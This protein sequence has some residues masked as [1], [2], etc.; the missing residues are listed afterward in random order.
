MT[1]KQTALLILVL[2]AILRFASQTIHAAQPVLPNAILF[3]TQP[4]IPNEVND[5][6][7]L[8]VF[9]SV[10]SPLGNHLADTA[11]AGRGGDLWIRYPNG[12]LKNLTR[13]A[14]FGVDGPQHGAG[15]GVRDPH[16]HWSG[17]KA[18]FSMVVGAP[19]VAGDPAQ[20]FWQLYEITNLSA[21]VA[22]SNTVPAIVKVLNQ[23]AGYNNVMPCYGTDERVIFAC[24]R[25]RNG[26]PH[27]YPQL[28]EY[29]D[30]PTNTGLWS[31]DPSTGDLFQLEHSPSGSFNPFIDS[32]GRLLFTRWDHLVQDR[33]ATDDRMGRATNGTFNYYDEAGTAYS[34]T[35]RPIELFPEPRTYDSNLLAVLKVQGNAFNQFFPWMANEDGTA[36]EIL[37]HIGRHELLSTFRGSSFTNDPNLVQQFNLTSGLRYNTNSLNNFMEVREDPLNAG[38]YFGIDSPD[39]G[40]HGAGQI[41]TLYGPPGT[42]ADRMFLTYITPK[43]TD[44]P[45]S[46]G[47]YRNPLPLSNGGLVAAY[48]ATPGSALD[49]NVGSPAF[50]APRYNFRLMTLQ[51]SGA[52]WTTNQFLTSGLTNIATYWNGSTLITQTNG[53]WEL[54]PVEV[55]ARP[56]PARLHAAVAAVEAQVFAEEGVDIAAMQAWLAANGLALLVSRNVTTRD[57][58]DREQPFNLRVPGT[59]TQTLGTNTGTVYGVRYIQFFQADQLRGL[60]FGTTNLAPGRRVLATP[61]HEPAALAFNVPAT[62]GPPGSTRLGDD[63]SQA[64][65]LPARR[66]M[67]HQLTDANGAFVTRERYWLTYQPGEIR[68]CTSCHGINTTDQAGQLAPTNKPQALRDLLRYWKQQ[69]GYA[70]IFSVSLTNSALT[71]NIS[72][73]PGRTNLIETTTDLSLW[74]SIGATNPSGNGIFRFDDPSYSSSTQRFY[75]VKVP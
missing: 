1:N 16:V 70:K 11:H 58:A 26:A 34:L 43:S 49:S 17:A 18:I 12:V 5:A 50:P 41:V 73:A 71:L 64:S 37:N 51:K 25:P 22:D 10:A 57:H 4:P 28:D 53:L 13:A 20:F 65:F 68:T 67:T 8:N 74:Q 29:N 39:F 24:D 61:L 23:P 38:T 15:I 46:F 47:V 2:A 3:V 59:A 55:I 7:V 19:L 44:A 69:T 32:F 35:N 40:T 56:V 30:V 36:Q 33:N 54:E 60:T 31:L 45:N 52:T 66:A 63:G 6:N 21:V 27:L 42:N 75:R 14:G 62:N 48:T 9:V 72:A